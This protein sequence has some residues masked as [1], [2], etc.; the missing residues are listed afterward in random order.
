MKKLILCF[1]LPLTGLGQN[2][3]GIPDIINY[4]KADYKAGLQNWDFKQDN[5]G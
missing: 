1:L 4:S 2:T 3:I 5:N